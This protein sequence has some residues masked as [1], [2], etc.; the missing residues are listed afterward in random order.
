VR[1]D[2]GGSIV[3]RRQN[4]GSTAS[5]IADRLKQG[6]RRSVIET[7]CRLIQQKYSRL[8]KNGRSERDLSVLRA[9]K[10]P[11]RGV[12]LLLGADPT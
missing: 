4:D 11:A 8:A 6:G 12:L 5:F 1:A 10:V 2:P 9:R 7:S 3:M